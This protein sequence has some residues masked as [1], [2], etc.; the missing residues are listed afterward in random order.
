MPFDE[1]LAE[2]IR[3]ALARKKNIEEKRMFG[4]VGFLLNGN[5]LV[6]VWK[7]SLVVRLGLDDGDEALLE[8]HVKPFDI[9]GRAMKGWVLVE[10]QG[11]E[12]DDLLNG[13]VQRAIKFVGKLPPK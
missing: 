9:T 13:W 1:N 5:M 3:H 11:V 10:A 12:S 6:G 2:R 8:Q 7:D 4:G